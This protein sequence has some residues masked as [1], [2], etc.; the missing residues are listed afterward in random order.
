[1]KI[2]TE[3]E[4][5]P[6]FAAIQLETKAEYTADIVSSAAERDGA[7][8]VAMAAW[9]AGVAASLLRFKLHFEEAAYRGHSLEKIHWLISEWSKNQTNDSEAF[10]QELLLSRPF[11]LSQ[12]FA[13]PVVI[14]GEQFLVGGVRAGGQHGKIVD[15]LLRNKLTDA[16]VIVELKTP[17]D[18]LLYKKEYRQDVFPPSRELSGA[19]M[20]VLEQRAQFMKQMQILQGESEPTGR[21]LRL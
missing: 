20:Q 15:Y 4:V 21:V 7:I 5:D 12:L 6:A 2:L 10:W 18:P 11:A 8:S 16:A 1:M 17:T 3:N 19:V 14:H 13:A 9:S